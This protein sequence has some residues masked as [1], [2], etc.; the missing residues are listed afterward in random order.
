MLK[1]C[2]YALKLMR[3]GG[4]ASVFPLQYGESR[5]VTTYLTFDQNVFD[6][7]DVSALREA[8]RQA[9]AI[10]GAVDV[11]DQLHVASIVLGFY[12]HGVRDPA[13]LAEIALFASS[14]R[15]FRSQYAPCLS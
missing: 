13:R 12:K 6:R 14:S 4:R 5:L 10:T 2:G 3:C 9:S 15:A 8:V 7:S 11:Q 1:L